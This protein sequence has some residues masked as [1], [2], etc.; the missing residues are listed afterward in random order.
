MNHTIAPSVVEASRTGGAVV[1]LE[2]TVVTH[3]LPRPENLLLARRL[4]QVVREE[5]ATPATIGVLD[6]AL[7]VGLSEPELERLASETADKAS[8]W[9]LA[10]LVA[11]RRHAGTTVATT[12]FAAARAGISVF[13]TGGIG[14]VHDRAFDESADLMALARYRMVTVCAGPKSILDAA[15]TLERLESLGVAV[16]GYRSDTLA[17]FLVP[18]T[19]LPLPSRIESAADVAAV[20]GAQRSLDLDGGVLVSNP[21][22]QGID[23]AD[24]DAWLERARADMDEAGVRGRDSTPY[25]LSRVAELSNG[26]SVTVNLRLLE[27]NARL[28]ARIA[29]AVA[30]LNGDVDRSAQKDRRWA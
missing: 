4:E 8:T 19:E 6:G 24:M 11:G 10:A 30:K 22:S 9:N 28:A 5:G 26:R 12:L 2:S 13:A 25:L 23:R 29:L 14:G 17:G 21:V 3:G 27:E 15:A 18:L 7:I 20:L 1:A 16:L